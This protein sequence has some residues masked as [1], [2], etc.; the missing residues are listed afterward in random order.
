MT[1]TWSLKNEPFEFPDSESF[2]DVAELERSTAADRVVNS[3]GLPDDIIA[4]I[5]THLD[6]RDVG[7][8]AQVCK[9]W[10]RASLKEAVW[11]HF[12][13]QLDLKL[14][15]PGSW[16]TSVVRAVDNWLPADFCLAP[17]SA[18]TLEHDEGA[19]TVKIALVSALSENYVPVGKTSLAIRFIQNL[20]VVEYD[21]TIEDS[22]MRIFEVDKRRVTLDVLDTAGQEEYS[23]MRE[24]WIRDRQVFVIC[25]TFEHPGTMK[26]IDDLHSLIQRWRDRDNVPIILVRTKADLGLPFA[27]KATV[28]Q[29]A[30][31]NGA[32][33]V[34]TSSRNCINV[35]EPFKM[36]ARMW[37]SLQPRRV[38]IRRD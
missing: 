15:A 36:A 1:H 23:A 26:Q 14:E 38:A 9:T 22:Y 5:A 10:R 21:P 37:L 29:W 17:P 16:R 32:R 2:F 30:R 28:L 12:A 4:L 25:S 3:L 19:A 7:R 11:R 27:E 31:K 8:V 35:E 6:V 33:L 13:K 20:E 34:S 24:M 18:R